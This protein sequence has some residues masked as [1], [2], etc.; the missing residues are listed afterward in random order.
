MLRSH[1]II[2]FSTLVV[3][4]SFQVRILYSPQ[5]LVLHVDIFVSNF[6]ENYFKNPSKLKKNPCFVYREFIVFSFNICLF[7]MLTF[8]KAKNLFFHLDIEV[9]HVIQVIQ[10]FL[11]HHFLPQISRTFFPPSIGLL[12]L[13]LCFQFCHYDQAAFQLFLWDWQINSFYERG[14]IRRWC[15]TLIFLDNTINQTQET[16]RA[17]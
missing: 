7:I 2:A 4:Y 15:T 12:T 16:L 9:F 10:N 11:P 1:T 6:W 5:S 3:S 8:F 17:A 13:R 14:C